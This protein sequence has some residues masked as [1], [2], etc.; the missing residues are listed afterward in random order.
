M[1]LTADV[2]RAVGPE[3]AASIVAAAGA[4]QAGALVK[5]LDSEFVAALVIELGVGLNTHLVSCCVCVCVFAYCV[6][7]GGVL[8]RAGEGTGQ[9]FC[10]GA[11]D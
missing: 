6:C 8:R 9:R 11:G 2:V 3:F 5:A 10:G 7:V 1:P 4:G